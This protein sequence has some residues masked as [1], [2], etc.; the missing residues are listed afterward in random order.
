MLPQLP[1]SR[2]APVAA[3]IEHGDPNAI[4]T[5]LAGLVDDGK[6]WVWV[7]EDIHWGDGAT[8]DLL[9]FVARRVSYLPLLVLAS[10]RD[11]EVGPQH[12]LSV[13]LGDLAATRDG[14]ISPSRAG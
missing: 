2:S 6:P 9:R 3:A 7:I 8:F 12:P 4:Y 11:D 5:E 1:E 13:V 10:Y 14:A